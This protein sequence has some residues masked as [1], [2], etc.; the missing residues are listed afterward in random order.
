M[1][2]CDNRGK[3]GVHAVIHA[4]ILSCIYYHYGYV[5]VFVG[6]LPATGDVHGSSLCRLMM[7]SVT[8]LQH[9]ISFTCDSFT[10]YSSSV[11]K[12]SI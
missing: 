11:A 4:Y 3:P 10:P 7:K 5:N 12:C 8:S 2:V 9:I 1:I 6:N